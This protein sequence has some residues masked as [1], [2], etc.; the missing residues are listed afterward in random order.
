M[1]RS[2][3]QSTVSL[4]R[5]EPGKPAAPCCRSC[6]RQQRDRAETPSARAQ[7]SGRRVPPEGPCPEVSPSPVWRS[8]CSALKPSLSQLIHNQFSILTHYSDLMTF[9]TKGRQLCGWF[10]FSSTAVLEHAMDW[11]TRPHPALLAASEAGLALQ[12][13]AGQAAAFPV[14]VAVHTVLRSRKYTSIQ[15]R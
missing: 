11:G 8:V 5:P 13:E 15:M 9:L 14:S 7:R 6:G 12:S 3:G 1:G 2:D 10:V 4:P